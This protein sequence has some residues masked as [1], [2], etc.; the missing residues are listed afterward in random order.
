MICFC[1]SKNVLLLRRAAAPIPCRAGP[2]CSVPTITKTIESTEQQVL[3]KG[4]LTRL[5][6]STSFNI[7]T[8][9]S[10]EVLLCLLAFSYRQP[11]ISSRSLLVSLALLD[12]YSFSETRKRILVESYEKSFKFSPD[13]NLC[14]VFAV[15]DP[16]T[17]MEFRYFAAIRFGPPHRNRFRRFA[18]AFFDERLFEEVVR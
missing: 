15:D 17:I 9:R 13:F 11:W 8:N 4:N 2:G 3:E 10:A 6:H 5:N 18:L 14:S 7:S 16:R 1:H 12:E